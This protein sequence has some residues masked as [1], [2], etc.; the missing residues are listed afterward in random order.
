MTVTDTD[1]SSLDR[2]PAPAADRKERTSQSVQRRWVARAGWVL[3]ILVLGGALGWAG[4]VVLRPTP[5]VPTAAGFVTAEAV[6][7]QVGSE[8]NLAV[9]AQWTRAPAAS[10]RASGIVTAVTPLDGSPIAAGAV[11]YKVDQRP[12]V[13]AVGAVPAYRDLGQGARGEDVRQLETLLGGLGH[14]TSA[15]DDR[16]E[17]DTAAA[18]RDWQHELGVDPQG[19]VRSGDMVFVDQLPARLVLDGEVISRGSTLGGGEAAVLVLADQPEFVLEITQEQADRIPIGTAVQITAPDG[20]TWEAVTVES[21]PGEAGAVVIQLAAVAGGT[22]C[23][24]ACT[25]VPVGEPVILDSEVVTDPPVSGVTVPVA[26]LRSTASGDV[27][28]VAPDGSERLVTIEASVGGTAVV[29]GIA[30]GDRVRVP[31]ADD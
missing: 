10:N 1:D 6:R 18:V 22:I 16:F 20:Q 7:G 5:Q 12:V 21:R 17:S 24:D 31:V 13:I 3:A 9:T 25:Q 26:A 23:A 19:V 30:A 14:L 4:A 2:A 29:E 15:A 11:L 28:V 27:V 8:L